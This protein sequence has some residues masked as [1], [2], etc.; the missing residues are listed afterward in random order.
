[1]RYSSSGHTCSCSW[2][3]SYKTVKFLSIGHIFQSKAS[4]A[5]YVRR[6]KALILFLFFLNGSYGFGVP[7]WNCLGVVCPETLCADPLTPPGG[8]CPSCDDSEC[9][10]E[11]CVQFLGQPGSKTVQWK[12]EGC[13]TCQCDDNG[14][15]LCYAAFCPPVYPSSVDLC[16]GQS[17]VTLPWECCPVCDYGTPEGGCTVVEDRSETYQLGTEGVGSTCSVD[18]TFH[19]CDKR[20]FMNDQGVRFECTPVI[21]PKFVELT[22][23]SEDVSGSCGAI[24]DLVY[25]DVVDCSPVRNDNLDVGCDFL[26]EE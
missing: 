6:M 13:T 8:C 1:M 20:G 10:F 7:P 23:D 4:S 17:T 19:R 12:P 3:Q 24:T 5:T 9:K 16:N 14:H 2:A 25:E 18:L 15:T 26:V 21:M 22:A 11:G